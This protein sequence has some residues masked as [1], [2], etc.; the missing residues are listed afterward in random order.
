MP[1]IMKITH[2][3]LFKVSH[4]F[5][6]V[7]LVSFF[8]LKESNAQKVLDWETLAKVN[9]EIVFDEDVM[10]YY[11]IPE[12]SDSVKSYQN[13]QVTME[14]YLIQMDTEDNVHILSRYPYASCFF[15]GGAGPESVVELQ[16]T[17]RLKGIYMDQRVR[18]RGL[19]IL[20]AEDQNHFN[21]I[22]ERADFLNN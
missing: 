15:C 19:F 8:N 13:R 2:R 12:F 7:L 4:I 20:N 16:M 14:G 10:S 6:F 21:Y 18:V 11:R 1:S 5:S 22:I 9:F 3:S 17:E